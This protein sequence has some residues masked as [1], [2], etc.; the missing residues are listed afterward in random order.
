MISPEITEELLSGPFTA[1]K[2]DEV[3]ALMVPADPP[4]GVAAEDWNRPRTAVANALREEFLPGEH[5]P[6]ASATAE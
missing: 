4:A 3:A 1:A 2:A 5:M 6:Q